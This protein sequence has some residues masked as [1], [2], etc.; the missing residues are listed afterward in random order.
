MQ[1]SF[2]DRHVDLL[3]GKGTHPH[4]CSHKPHQFH[5]FG[6]Q[7]PGG[8]RNTGAAGKGEALQVGIQ[9]FEND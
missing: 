5:I 2:A 8:E 7:M 6:G 1:K 3:G 4:L 9:S